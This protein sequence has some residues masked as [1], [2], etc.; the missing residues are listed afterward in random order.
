MYAVMHISD[1]RLPDKPSLEVYP[2]VLLQRPYIAMLFARIIA[3]WSDI[4]GRL[5]AIFLLCVRDRAALAELQTIKGWDARCKFFIQNV[6]AR[7]GDTLTI[8]LRA[9]LRYVALPSKKRHDIAHGILA[10]CKE[11]PDDLVVASPE[12]YTVAFGEALRAE[13]EGTS[14][15]VLN[16][17]SLFDTARVVTADHLNQLLADLGEARNL[18]HNFMIEKTPSIVHVHSREALPRAA[19]HPDIAG[20]IR[21]AKAGIKKRDKRR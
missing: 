18:M 5:E 4:E 10:L 14:K 2:D 7:Q 21:N 6:Q 12:M 13:A 19:D 16:K 11:L 9:I 20:R 1:Q 8:E 3:T 17:E 15:L